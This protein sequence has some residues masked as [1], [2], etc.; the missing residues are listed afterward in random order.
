[1]IPRLD[2]LYWEATSPG[3]QWSEV[4]SLSTADKL[5]PCL[6]TNEARNIVRSVIHNK[7]AQDPEQVSFLYNML[8]FKGCNSSG[9][10]SEFRVRGGTQAVPLAIAKKLGDNRMTMGDPVQSVRVLDSSSSSQQRVKSMTKSGK[11]FSCKALI[12]TGS[13]PAILGIDFEPPLPVVQTQLLKQMPMGTCR[14]FIAVYKRGPWWRQFGYTGDVLA[15]GLPRELSIKSET[16]KDYVPIFGQCF[17]T[18]PYSQE[19]GVLTCFVEGRQN[20]NFSN[21]SEE[22]QRDLMR[23]FLQLTFADLL[24]H[25]NAKQD[26]LWKP[27][28]YVTHNWADDPYT[29]GAYTAYFPPGVLSVPEWWEAYRSMEKLPNVFLAGADYHAGYGNGY[30]EGAVRSGQRAAD[31]VHDRLRG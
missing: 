15:S 2:D 12:L 10:D 4:D 20:E 14:K 30:I 3:P 17:D 19:F 16:E 11:V 18:S 13:P 6:T 1:M 24:D 28:Y 9:A 25:D 27:D 8:S 5:M 22:E 23:R 29:C 21:L 31:L 7:N 26:E